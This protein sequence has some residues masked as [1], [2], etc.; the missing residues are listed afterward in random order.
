MAHCSASDNTVRLPIGILGGLGPYATLDL[1]E[2]ILR[3]TP[4]K[5]DQE[6]LH[7]IIDNNPRIPDRTAALLH[8]GPSPLPAMLES[9]LRLQ[10]AGVQFIVIPCNTAH[11]FVPDL[12]RRLQVPI[13]NMI[14]ACR[15]AILRRLPEIQRIGLL[16]TS[17]TV[18]SG[19]YAKT[20]DAAGIQTLCPTAAESLVMQSSTGGHPRGAKT[21]WPGGSY[22][23]QQRTYRGGSR[24]AHSGCTEIP[25]RSDS[26][27]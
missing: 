19:V 2:K 22:C 23:R 15:A 21:P 25:L 3:C 7:I 12:Q 26:R 24:G 17:G 5:S 9:A 13:L 16:A 1:F 4:A 14:E 27:I 8:G 11:A 20:L 10:Q 6:H 18:R